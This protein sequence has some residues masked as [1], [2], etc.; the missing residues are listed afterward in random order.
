LQTAGITAVVNCTPAHAFPTKEQLSCEREGEECTSI[1]Q[2]RVAVEDEDDAPIE[3]HFDDAAEFIRGVIDG[4][5]KIYVHCETG[6]SRSAAIVLAYRV[7]CRGESL[8]AAYDD[9]KA[10]R[11]YIQPKV[12]FFGKI[13]AREREWISSSGDGSAIFEFEPSFPVEEYALVYLQDHFEAYSW[14][15]G[16]DAEAVERTYTECSQDYNA[17]FQQIT[18]LVNAALS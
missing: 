10:I 7:K 17:T 9:T 14:A 1:A 11:S 12:A 5:G 16:I 3:Q 4:G 13:A 15:P 6:K 8:R 2:F 18:A